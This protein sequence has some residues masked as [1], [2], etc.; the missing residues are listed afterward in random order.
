MCPAE[1]GAFSAPPS[2]GRRRPSPQRRP[3]FS[4][5]RKWIAA[6]GR[7]IAV[8]SPITFVIFLALTGAVTLLVCE[9]GKQELKR[10]PHCH[11]ALGTT[12]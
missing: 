2:G 9:A 7:V 8:W 10:L 4:E 11:L 1:P 12:S 5:V 3:I 6:T